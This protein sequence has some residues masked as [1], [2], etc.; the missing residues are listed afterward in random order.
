[1]RVVIL[2]ELLNFGLKTVCVTLDQLAANRVFLLGLGHQP[3]YF[4]LF[5]AHVD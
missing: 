1:M 4:A 3:D 2:G 5:A